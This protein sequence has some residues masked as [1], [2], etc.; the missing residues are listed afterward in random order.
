MY[1]VQKIVAYMIAPGEPEKWN[2]EWKGYPGDN[3]DEPW[4]A[5]TTEEQREMYSIG[6]HPLFQ[7]PAIFNFLQCQYIHFRSLL[8]SLEH[9]FLQVK[10][11]QNCCKTR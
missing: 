1:V 10:M 4:S 3:T 2:I 6:Q 7:E 9:L 11:L 8:I 5:F